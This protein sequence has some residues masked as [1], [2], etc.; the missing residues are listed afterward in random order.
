[1]TIREE[2]TSILYSVKAANVKLQVFTNKPRNWDNTSIKDR[3]EQ[4]LTLM[5]MTSKVGYL[6]QEIENTIYRLPEKIRPHLF[7]TEH[8]TTPVHT[9]NS[10]IITGSDIVDVQG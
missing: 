3:D 10:D 1:M 6:L 7:K 5:G 4:Y 9:T 2:L 8:L